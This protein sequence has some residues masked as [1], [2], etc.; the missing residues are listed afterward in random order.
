M[1]RSPPPRPRGKTVFIP[2]GTYQVNRHIVVD[3]VTIQG[4]GNWWSIVRGTEVTLD[5]PLPDGSIHTGVGL[6]RQVRRGRRQQ[7]RPPG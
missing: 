4:A 7:Q 6:L 3:D 1:P 5:A 2:A